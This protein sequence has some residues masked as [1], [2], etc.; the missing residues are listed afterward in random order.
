MTRALKSLPRSLVLAA[1]LALAM[2]SSGAWAGAVPEANSGNPG[3]TLEVRSLLAQ[4]KTTLID[5]YSPFCPPC[6]QLAPIMARLAAKR[7]DLAIKKVNINRPEVKEID[8]RSPLAQ[9]YQIRQVPYFMVFSPKG[10]L[11]A[12]G[13]EAAETV[14]RWLKEAG[15]MQ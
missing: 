12:Q 1:L 2:V 6:V 9:Q 7:P 13:R 15:L 5:F 14:G 11:V 3:Q 4:G 10:Q 8:W